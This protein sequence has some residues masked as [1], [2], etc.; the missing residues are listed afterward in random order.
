MT[1]APEIER[2]TIARIVD[3]VTFEQ[4]KSI[5]RDNPIVAAEWKKALRKADAI[6]SRMGGEPVAW[7]HVWRDDG[8]LDGVSF[9][10]TEQHFQ[11]VKTIPLYASRF[12]LY[13][14]ARVARRAVLAQGKGD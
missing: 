14:D 4:N 13:D 3:P 5:L 10:K 2:E 12:P 1:P 11:N 9:T 7:M 8:S 6:L